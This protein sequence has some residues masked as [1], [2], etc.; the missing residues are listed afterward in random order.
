MKSY[1]NHDISPR[2]KIDKSVEE[3][4]L[5]RRYHRTSYNFDTGIEYQNKID[6]VVSSPIKRL[7]QKLNFDNFPSKEISPGPSNIPVLTLS[8]YNRTRPVSRQE[9]PLPKS[10]RQKYAQH[11]RKNP[12]SIGDKENAKNSRRVKEAESQLVDNKFSYNI[13]SIDKI[14]DKINSVLRKIK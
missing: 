4:E 1:L 3:A 10:G 6:H 9:Q 7:D 13:N 14:Q 11:I 2:L 8:P 5:S 12:P